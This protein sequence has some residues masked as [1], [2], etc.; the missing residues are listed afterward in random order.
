MTNKFYVGISKVF[1]HSSLPALVVG[2]V[3][4]RDAVGEGDALLH[5]LEALGAEVARLLHAQHRVLR[6]GRGEKRD[7]NSALTSYQHWGHQFQETGIAMTNLN[8]ICI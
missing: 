4:P 3:W 6:A 5:G 2:A 7:M 8:I 1:L